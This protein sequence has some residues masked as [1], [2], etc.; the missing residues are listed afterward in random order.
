MSDVFT[1][2]DLELSEDEET[3]S[4]SGETVS[5]VAD[6][7]GERLDVF[8]AARIPA[9]SRSQVQRIVSEGAATVN[10]A[11][12][13]PS[14]KLFAG[15]AV[16]LTVPPLR[17]AT[18]KP[19]AI[20]L[21]IVYEDSDLLV[22]NKQKGL[23]VHPAPGALSGTLVN[24][25]L[26]HCTD[27]SG[28]G[29]QERPGI[30]HRLDKDTTG[31]MIVAKND[32]AHRSLQAQIQTKTAVRRYLAY[33]WGR[34]AF[35]EAVIDAP[36][37]RHLTDRKKMAVME[38]GGIHAGRSAQTHVSVR[39]P[40]GAVSLVECVL[41]TGRTHQIRVH[42]AY[43]GHPVVGDA[44]YG[45][46]KRVSPEWIPDTRARGLVNDHI[47]GM[48]GQALHSHSLSFTHPRTGETLSFTAPLP[49]EMATLQT[50]V[51]LSAR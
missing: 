13:K 17:D 16:T 43:I 26:H 28:I 23:V 40:H 20:P 22:I 9:L 48:T 8:L 36:L 37:G 7:S 18:A 35:N 30:V 51:Q 3:E 32:A 15:D 27:L 25:L 5:F 46:D 4:V 11:A 42:C 1:D 33:V 6:A 12:A 24:A 49:P 44:T 38:P 21:A 31:L 2:G 41:Q 19:E 14:Q 50:L 39:E 34:P 10:G 29:G 47:A 45:G